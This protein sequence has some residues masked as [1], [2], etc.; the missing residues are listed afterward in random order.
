MKVH[1]GKHH[2][3]KYKCGLCDLE[4]ASLENRETHLNT[5]EVFQCEWREK[6]EE[7]RK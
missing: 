2:S 7:T 4:T 5:S 3:E 6:K 1:L